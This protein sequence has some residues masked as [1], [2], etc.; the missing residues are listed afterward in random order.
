MSFF[1]VS[2]CSF[3]FSML[4]FFTFILSTLSCALGMDLFFLVDVLNALHHVAELAEVDDA[5]TV[6]VKCGHL[7]LDCF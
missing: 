5:R 2:M 1:F 6:L 4:R 7:L 3:L